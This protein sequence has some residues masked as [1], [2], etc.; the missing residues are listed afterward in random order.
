MYW[1]MRRM[2]HFR[3]WPIHHLP[4]QTKSRH[5]YFHYCRKNLKN[6]WMALSQMKVNVF[7]TQNGNILRRKNNEEGNFGISISL[8]Q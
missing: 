3:S 6:V 5:L 4:N 2:S 1:Q 8:D 7:N